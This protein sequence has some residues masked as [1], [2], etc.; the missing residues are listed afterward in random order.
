MK[1]EVLNQKM[2][3][4]LQKHKHFHLYLKLILFE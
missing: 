1:I 2:K 3:I 4:W